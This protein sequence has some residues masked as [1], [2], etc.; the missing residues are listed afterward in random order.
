M[1][2]AQRHAQILESLSDG[3]RTVSDLAENF[4]VSESTI[5]RDLSI[6]EKEGLLK[7]RYGGAMLITGSRITMTDS[8][9]VEDSLLD[10]DTRSD[11]E[12]RK[13]MAKSAAG[14]V[15]DGNVVILDVGS[16]TPL[17]A[18][19]LLGRHV[20]IVTSNLAVLDVVREDSGID[21]VMVGGA[22]RRNNQS[23]VG[24][25]AEEASKK[26]SA[27]IMFLSCTGVRSDS[28]VD[29]MEVE[30]PIKKAWIAA[31]QKIVLLA[32][33]KKYPGTGGMLLCHLD[34]VDTIVTTDG[35]PEE[36]IKHR[37]ESGRKVIIA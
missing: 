36:I 2:I 7:R 31:S 11:L 28:V 1:L 15:E 30:A 37:R 8:G 3:G 5:R 29:D 18:R 34:Q 6:L 4:G 13:R 27:D 20:V 21:L 26:I 25:L 33:E 23:L 10:S 17:L 16:T 35:T 9:A 12:L 32:S 24:P 22:L 14:L 19:E